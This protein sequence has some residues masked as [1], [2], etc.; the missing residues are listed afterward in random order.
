[1]D[2]RE[3]NSA[4]NIGNLRT[5]TP[6][7]AEPVTLELAKKH[8]RVEIDD[9]DDLIEIY[10]AAARDYAEQYMC[11]A[12]I[13]QEVELT[14]DHFPSIGIQLR[15]GVVQEVSSVSYVDSDGVQQ[16]WDDAEYWLGSSGEPAVLVPTAD[17]F[18]FPQTLYKPDAVK[19]RYWVGYEP[20]AGSPTDYAENV[21]PNVRNAILKMVDDSY[22]NRD[23]AESMETVDNLLW[24]YRILANGV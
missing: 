16:T 3:G 2:R 4:M 17:S 19:V 14:L 20:G 24:P 23:Q 11:R 18:G 8:S 22:N 12:I 13:R 21:P 9:D 5:V 10:I 6:P 1:M 7:A 15:G